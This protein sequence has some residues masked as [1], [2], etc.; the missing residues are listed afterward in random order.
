MYNQGGEPLQDAA[1]SL[2]LPV[3][4]DFHVA[5]RL[6]KLRRNDDFVERTSREQ[7]TYPAVTRRDSAIRVTGRLDAVPAGAPVELFASPL[8]ICVG[9]ALKGRR[10]GIQ[11][12]LTAENLRAP[13]K[14][15]LRLQF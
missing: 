13:A 11:F 14:G 5:G 12:S 2:V 6:P 7:S 4:E 3:H 8:R 10:F 1:Y 15:T 9:T